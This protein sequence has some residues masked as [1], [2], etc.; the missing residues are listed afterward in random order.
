ME[1]SVF[2][3]PKVM[4]IVNTILLFCVG[5]TFVRMK[6]D[7]LV[8]QSDALVQQSLNKNVNQKGTKRME[9]L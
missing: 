2:H 1:K 6:S 5:Y 9:I 7:A 4:F 8:Q 3:L